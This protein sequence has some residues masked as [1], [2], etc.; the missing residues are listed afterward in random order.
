MR[1]QQTRLSEKNIE[2]IHN[3]IIPAY[4]KQ[5]TVIKR[6]SELT[7]PDTTDDGVS[8]LIDFWEKNW[9]RKW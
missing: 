1:K 8:Y 5:Y 3:T 9:E 7:K 6:H 4:H 2:K